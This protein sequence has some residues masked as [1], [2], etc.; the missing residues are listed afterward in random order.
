MG[1][2][3]TLRRHPPPRPWR[4]PP[5]PRLNDLHQRG[6]TGHLVPGTVVL[7]LNKTLTSLQHRATHVLVHDVGAP[8]PG[9]KERERE[10]HSVNLENN[11]AGGA[12][13][14]RQ[15]SGRIEGQGARRPCGGESPT[16]RP[17]RGYAA[18]PL[19]SV[20]LKPTKD[21]EKKSAYGPR[22]SVI[23]GIALL[24]GTLSAPLSPRGSAAW[25]A[26]EVTRDASRR[27]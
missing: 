4:T 10:G 16:K 21:R 25:S 14:S 3:S 22:A 1:Q 27:P 12:G 5:A 18:A 26:G 9:V 2:S 6:R 20:Y 23:P 11:E 17:S 8:V 19:R 7:S 24:R 15:G 13:A